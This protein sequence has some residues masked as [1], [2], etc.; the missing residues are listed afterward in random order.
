MTSSSGR[1][2]RPFLLLIGGKRTSADCTYLQLSLGLRS[3][4]GL[5]SA[6]LH[7]SRIVAPRGS[8]VTVEAHWCMVRDC[9]NPLSWATGRQ[10][11]VR[12]AKSLSSLDCTPELLPLSTTVNRQPGVANDMTSG[13]KDLQG[14]SSCGLV[15]L[16]AIPLDLQLYMCSVHH[17]NL[18]TSGTPSMISERQ[19]CRQIVRVPRAG[20]VMMGPSQV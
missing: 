17:S 3:R 10:R 13:G 15:Q 8:S 2:K 7:Y 20:C 6:A 14:P 5:E 9:P 12:S 4:P 18:L 1:T 16:I 11:A 19:T